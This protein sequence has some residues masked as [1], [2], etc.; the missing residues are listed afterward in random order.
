MTKRARTDIAHRRSETLI[1]AKSAYAQVLPRSAD[2]AADP[3]RG[4][5]L[6]VGYMSPSRKR[7]ACISL[8]VRFQMSG[9]IPLTEQCWPGICP[10]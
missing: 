6:P 10:R 9:L 5:C 4:Q 2:E 7:R 1:C 8:G 3:Q